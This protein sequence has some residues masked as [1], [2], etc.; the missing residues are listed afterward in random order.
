MYKLE[1]F[2]RLNALDIFKKRQM[3][4]VADDV[5]YLANCVVKFGA[6]D[7][8][9]ERV[10]IVVSAGKID[11]GNFKFWRANRNVGKGTLRSLETFAGNVSLKVRISATI[12]NGVIFSFAVKLNDEFEIV[13]F[14]G[15]L[16]F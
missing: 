14:I 2:N 1:L 5:N 8:L 9:V 16:E 7:V 3:R 13:E 12:E 6:I 10:C 4:N 11:G 15:K